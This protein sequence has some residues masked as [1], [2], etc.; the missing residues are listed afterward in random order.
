MLITVLTGVLGC[1]SSKPDDGKKLDAQAKAD[2]RAKTEASAKRDAKAKAGQSEAK[3]DAKAEPPVADAKALDNNAQD[4]NTPKNDSAGDIPPDSI[5]P[6]TRPKGVP[7]DWQRVTGDVWSF[8]VP[9]DWAVTDVKED[10]GTTKGDKSARRSRTESGVEV[11]D[12]SCTVHS[13]EALPTK[14]AELKK[15]A[16]TRA[17]AAAKKHE[18]KSTTV[19]LELDEGTQD[20]LQLEYDATGDGTLVLERWLVT[21]RPLALVCSDESGTKDAANRKILETALDSLRWVVGE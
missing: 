4:T 11:S 2:T 21:K 3:A 16:E 12:L 15:E 8:W 19:K 7:D 10:D 13:Q 14:D 6:T 9:K 17:K 20:V 5:A 1:D 18:V